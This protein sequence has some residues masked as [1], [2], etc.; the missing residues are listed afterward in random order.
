ML[1]SQKQ[2]NKL[3][4]AVVDYEKNI[5]YPVNAVTRDNYNPTINTAKGNQGRDSLFASPMS[6]SSNLNFTSPSILSNFP[7]LNRASRLNNDLA[8]FTI[9]KNKVEDSPNSSGYLSQFLSQNKAT[10]SPESFMSLRSPTLLCGSLGRIPKAAMPW[11][12][13]GGQEGS[14]AQGSV[15]GNK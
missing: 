6:I 4:F 8:A 14:P 7:E 5:L 15:K 3:M 13:L 2:S 10:D 12:L 1:K 9:P 11:N